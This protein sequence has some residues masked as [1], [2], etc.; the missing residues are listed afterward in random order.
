MEIPLSHFEEY[1]DEPILKRGLS[2]FKKGFVH[3]PA[4]IRPGDYEAVV[5]GSEEYTVKL[6][7]R[8]RVI[9]EH[10]CNCP[11]DM[12]PVCKHVA[13]VIF[14]LEQEELGLTQST[15]KGS[16]KKAK[17]ASSK[18]T[19]RKTIAQQVDNLLDKVTHDELTLFVRELAT[20]DS[21]F[22]DLLL[23]SF[24]QY[25]PSESKA[26]YAKQVRAP[27]KVARSKYGY[28]DSSGAKY[29]SQEIS[30]MLSL[31]KHYLSQG[32]HKSAFFICTAIMDEL[33]SALMCADDREGVL[34]NAIYAAY[35]T[36]FAIASEEPSE[37]VRKQIL[38]YCFTSFDKRTFAGWD[39]HIGLLQLATCILDTE[40]EVEELLKRINSIPES[41]E[42]EIKE[43]QKIKY[44]ILLEKK[45]TEI[46]QKYIE[47]NIDNP[48]FRVRA[49]QEALDQ[50]DYE[51]ATTLANDGIKQDSGYPGLVTGWYEWLLKIAEIQ[52][53]TERIILYARHL[54]LES[55]NPKRDYYQILKETV[56]PE[57][58]TDFVEAIVQETLERKPYYGV[59]FVASIFVREE[60]WSRLFEL[61]KKE[62]TLDRLAKYEKPL[63]KHFPSELIDLYVE[64]IIE[65]VDD[66]VGRKYYRT[67]CRYIRKMIKLGA[68]DKADEVISQLRQTHYRKKA[69]MEELDNV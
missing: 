66:R 37:A 46:A 24:A 33:I 50:K 26:L 59:D 30:P 38:K 2:Y 9:T 52:H 40:D 6:S 42:Y 53:D 15:K 7:I 44:C 39:W 34:G 69:L 61:V 11:Y 4:E 43:A 13:A 22:R 62:Y 16:T 25:N 67:A 47:Q 3:E 18:P 58:W 60:W 8:N 10:S 48:T 64:R 19:K 63:A 57:E 17:A 1:I 41:D 54:L 65:Y 5:E 12:G 28:I 45:G 49:I 32:N 56:P 21:L 27:I 23:A 14:Y 36:L 29:I 31:A 20:K 35:N 55:H 68:K 51:K